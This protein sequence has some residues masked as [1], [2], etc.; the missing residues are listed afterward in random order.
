MSFE[1]SGCGSLILWKPPRPLRRCHNVACPSAPVRETDHPV[2]EGGALPDSSLHAMKAGINDN[3]VRGRF[4]DDEWLKVL[5]TPDVLVTALKGGAGLDEA[6]L[7]VFINEVYLPGLRFVSEVSGFANDPL[8]IN[9]VGDR[10]PEPMTFGLSPKEAGQE[11]VEEQ[12]RRQAEL[13]EVQEQ[14][15]PAEI[16][17]LLRDRLTEHEYRSFLIGLLFLGYKIASASGEP[18]REIGTEELLRLKEFAAEW[19]ISSSD[20]I[21]MLTHNFAREWK[22]EPTT[23]T[24]FVAAWRGDEA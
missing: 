21:T 7:K 5:V 15:R 12:V 24:E 3:G 8:A 1:A 4:D 17:R 19:G 20:F 18:G 11:M 6:E 2:D 10:F 13:Y 22:V 23:V 16:R 9:I 14:T